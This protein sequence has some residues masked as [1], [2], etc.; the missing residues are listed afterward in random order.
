MGSEQRPEESVARRPPPKPSVKRR[1][2]IPS[3]I[4]VGEDQRLATLRL[5]LIAR[6]LSIFRVEEV[7]VYGEDGELTVK[8]LRYAETPQY[9]R[10]KVI[11]LDRA[12]KYCGVIP[13]LQSPH[14][15]PS[16]RG[17]GFVCEYREGVVLR[18]LKDSVLVD[19]GL[20]R[21][22]LARGV[23]RPRERVTVLLEGEPRVVDRSEVP[24]YWGYAVLTA[25][26]LR[27][28]VRACEGFLRV[29]T[30]RIGEPIGRVAERIAEDARR[31]GKVAVFFG[32]RER[33]VIDRALEEGLEP[34]EAFHYVVNLVPNQGT[35][36]IR[37]EEAIPIALSILE[38]LI[39]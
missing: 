11:P 36:T 25:P 21:P 15:P 2:V 10:R 19:V 9:L 6:Y 33:G 13:P 18:A 38:L 8:T 32:E 28:A 30:S 7:L 35:F 22:I 24:Y 20:G 5:G 26:D 14:H 12:L 17:R 31:V 37:T 27:G 4:F 3:N 16:L 39:D 23:A 34:R 1:V 29:A